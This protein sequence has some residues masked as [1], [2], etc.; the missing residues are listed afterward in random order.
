MLIIYDKNKKLVI[1]NMGTN[2]AFPDGN[3]PNLPELQDGHIYIR[4]PDNSEDAQKIMKA[5]EY[6]I[7]LDKNHNPHINIIKT[8]DDFKNE[9]SQILNKIRKKRNQMLINSDYTMLED[10]SGD[11]LAWKEYRKQLRDITKQ[12]DFNNIIWPKRPGRR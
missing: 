4:I 3:I 12:N 10:F 7:S 2:S 9:P 6:E 11:K 8:I 1:N 5:K